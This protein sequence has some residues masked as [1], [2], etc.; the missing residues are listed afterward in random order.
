MHFMSSAKKSAMR[1]HAVMP[2]MSL[3]WCGGKGGGGG[4]YKQT[5]LATA[6]PAKPLRKC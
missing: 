1:K 6:K 4:P 3:I 5:T 2:C